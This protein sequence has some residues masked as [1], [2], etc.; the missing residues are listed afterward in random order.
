MVQLAADGDIADDST[1]RW[2]ESRPQVEFGEIGLKSL[3]ENDA[4]LQRHII[5]D[6]IPR[7]DGIESSGDPIL[8][9]RSSIYLMSGRRHRHIDGK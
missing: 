5:F 6:A 4:A 3:V 9:A 1:E 7:V 2:P 8:E